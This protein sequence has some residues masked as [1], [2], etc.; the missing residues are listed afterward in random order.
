L[1]KDEERVLWEEMFALLNVIQ[2]VED[3]AK[4]DLKRASN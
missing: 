2:K 3:V 1:K 4:Q